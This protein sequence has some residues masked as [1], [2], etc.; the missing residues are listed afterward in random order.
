MQLIGAIKYS[1]RFGVERRRGSGEAPVR[2]R[3]TYAGRRLDFSLGIRMPVDDWD[4]RWQSPRRGYKDE[5]EVGRTLTAYRTRVDDIFARFQLVEKRLPEPAELR[6]LVRKSQ[7][8]PEATQKILLLSCLDEF[9]GTVSVQ[10]QWAPTTNAKFAVVRAHLQRFNSR[11]RLDCLA[12]SDLQSYVEYLL[13]QGLANTTVAK[14]VELVRWF[15]RWAFK[16][17]YYTGSLHE[18]WRPHF[19]GVDGMAREVIYLAWDELLHLY[20]FQLPPAKRHLARVRDVFCFLCFTGLRFSDV[21]KLRRS[22]VKPQY[23]Q[24]VTQ[25][26]MECIKVE[27]NKYSQAILE[28]YA[29][30]RVGNPRAL[31]VLSNAAMNRYVKVVAALAGIAEPQRVVYFKGARRYEKVLPKHALLSTHCGRRTFIVNALYLGIPAEVVMKWTGHAD[32]KSMKPYVKIVDV[33]KEKEMS[34]FNK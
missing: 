17:G 34:K 8:L 33:L 7:K 28:R 29:S 25:K 22:D 26:T 20:N 31:P 12:E 32:Y 18:E 5:Q 19:K 10:N 27:L 30:K 24:L 4:E 15:L 3:L 13:A 9:L 21:L 23:I 1:V 6:T 2:M 14:N 16:K 11:L